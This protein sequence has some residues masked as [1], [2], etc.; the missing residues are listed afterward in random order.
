MSP[1]ETHKVDEIFNLVT[2]SFITDQDVK[3]AFSQKDETVSIFVLKVDN[4]ELLDQQRTY[5]LQK[6]FAEISHFVYGEEHTLGLHAGAL[7]HAV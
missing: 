6:G 4:F 3:E 1:D 2:L 5:A 7:N